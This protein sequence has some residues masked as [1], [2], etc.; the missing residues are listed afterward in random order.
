MRCNKMPE[1]IATTLATPGKAF[2][3]TA[4]VRDHTN[5]KGNVQSGK[6]TTPPFW[7]GQFSSS[8]NMQPC[9]T[10]DLHLTQQTFYEM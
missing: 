4:Y 10:I 1:P 5:D 7:G 9:I 8:L 6:H 2:K 3:T